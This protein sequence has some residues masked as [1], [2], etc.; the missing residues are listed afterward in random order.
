MLMS[1]PELEIT[2]AF[3]FLLSLLATV[4]F[5]LETARPLDAFNILVV[6]PKRKFGGSITEF[7]FKIL[8]MQKQMKRFCTETDS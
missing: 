8:G 6:F 5:L 1:S 7:E 3:L 2:H 4:S